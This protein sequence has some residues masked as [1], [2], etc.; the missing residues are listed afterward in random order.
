MSTPVLVGGTL[1]R[2]LAVV[3]RNGKAL[4]GSGLS[5]V[6]LVSGLVEPLVYL[7]AVGVGVGELL[8]RPVPRDGV[9]VPYPTYVALG[10]LAASAMFGAVGGSTFAFFAK[11]RYTGHFT[12]VH[13]AAVS[14]REIVLGELLWVALRGLVFDALFLLVM[15]ALGLVGGLTALALLPVG[16]LVTLAFA[17][18]AM[19]L[20]TLLRGWQDFDAVTAVLTV[21]FLFSGTFFPVSNYPLVMEGLVLVSP[22]YHGVELARS[23]GLGQVDGWFAVHLLYLGGMVVGGL[24][25]ARRR[26][27]EALTS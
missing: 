20:T 27:G 6:L 13:S 19:G 14:S 23:V 8:Q 24:V 25:F 17:A 1:I 3:E 5:W 9:E 7:L 16:L 10:M 22:L 15:V 21:L 2:T 4:R 18:V 26:V 12:V 11:L